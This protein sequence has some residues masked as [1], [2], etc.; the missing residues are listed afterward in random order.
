[1]K[2]VRIAL[3]AIWM[4]PQNIWGTICFL[5][6]M[7]TDWITGKNSR[8]VLLEQSQIVLYSESQESGVSLG[9]F[10]IVPY[11]TRPYSKMVTVMA[12]ELGHRKQSE[13][14]GPLYL[15]V[16]G[17]PSLFYNC[18]QY[19]MA[20]LFGVYYFSDHYYDFYTEKWADKLGQVNR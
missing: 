16:I 14:L 3:L 6:F 2:Y 10:I 1:M 15:L 17:I 9:F 5:W 13:I 4:L 7:F 12:H 20:D 11:L 8:V 19:I 18:F